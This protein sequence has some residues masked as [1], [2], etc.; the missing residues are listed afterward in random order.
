MLISEPRKVLFNS[1]FNRPILFPANR[2][3]LYTV[4]GL[5]EIAAIASQDPGVE[6]V[7]ADVRNRGRRGKPQADSEGRK[8][9]LFKD[10]L[11][12]QSKRRPL[13]ACERLLTYVRTPLLLTT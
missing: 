10:V 6:Y 9:V 12:G 5:P 8:Q 7:K 11:Y 13:W 3:T 1:N 4:V 2:Y